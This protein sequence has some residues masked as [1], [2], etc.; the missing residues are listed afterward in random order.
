MGRV[1][2]AED[3]IE[4]VVW[5]F[6]DSVV[7]A[8]ALP[9][10]SLCVVH[11][12]DT[13]AARGFGTRDRATGEPVTADTLF[14]LAS[15]SKSFVATAVLQLVESGELDLE[16][17]ITAYLPDLPWSDPRARDIMVRHLL[18]HTSGVGDVLDYGWHEPELDDGAL[19]RFATR[20]AGWPLEGDPGQRFAY[21]NSAYE[22]LGHLVATTG[23]QSFE[24]LLKE[25]VLDPVG[26]TTSTFLRAD[27][28]PDAS[29]APHLGMPPRVVDGAYPYTRRH[30]P[31]STLHSSAT[32][33]G[34]WMASQLAGGAGLMSPATHA[35]MWQ[36]HAGTGWDEGHAW[37]ALGWFSGTYRGQLLVG[38]SGSDPGFG[39]NLALVPEL[40]L[41]VA[42]MANS[43]TAPI[44]AITR[45][46]LD[47]LLGLEPATPPLPPMTVPV[48]PVLN[49]SGPSA[50]ADLYRR[51]A[52]ADP[53][54][55]DLDADRFSDAGWGAVEM[56]RTDLVWPLIEL[57]HQ[58]QPESSAAW[59][60]T[61]W[62][63]E[64]D[65]RRD[66]ALEH[67]RRAVDLD[68]DNDEALNFLRHLS[69]SRPSPRSP[70]LPARPRARASSGPLPA[71]DGS[72]P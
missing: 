67:L 1:R 59:F 7:E 41:G 22:L 6:V 5:P 50:A 32:E 21:S 27:I 42:V 64:V 51:L 72:S 62:A 53:L 18:S 65:G 63:H 39:T 46:A 33:L 57:W 25:R 8:W 49:R 44:F 71:E 26:M 38:H 13:V 23:R 66:A 20:V 70:A 11:D 54:T 24:A 12:G 45:A 9:G 68:P 36:P 40:G 4:A 16:G 10:V 2:E 43:N 58:V 15:I 35:L 19:S 56:H 28:P 30:A 31:S 55:V 61:G 69:V 48:A 34:R 3:R 29:A 52:D 14:H 60:T 37:V 47:V 17:G